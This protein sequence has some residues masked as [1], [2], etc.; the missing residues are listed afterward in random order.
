MGLAQA[1]VPEARALDGIAHVAF[2][3]SDL[4]RSRGFY[5]NLGFEQAFEFTDAKGATVSYIKVN[6]RQFIELYRR[7]E[8]SQALGLMH[9]CF[10]A[11]DLAKVRAAYVEH[12]LKPVEIVKARA[13]N[14]LFNLRDPEGQVLEYTQYMPG[15]LHSNERGK[16]LGAKR[17]SGQL[18]GASSSVRDLGAGRDFYGVLG[19]VKEQS[20]D[21]LRVPGDS[22]EWVQL[23]ALTPEWKPR[24]EFV[25]EDMRRAADELKSR[26]MMVDVTGRA[27]V[28]RDPDG[29]TLSF[30]R[31][32]K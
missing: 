27:A 24:L 32:P 12:G 10:D 28:V 19:F 1:P 6:D 20:G 16:H 8:Q 29:V 31:E 30:S 23:E 25:V 17:I 15:S 11:G 13:G 4:S 14:L 5:E 21:R 3:V 7:D 9:I 22:S 18:R 2:R 26:G